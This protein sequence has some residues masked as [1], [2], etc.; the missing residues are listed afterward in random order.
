MS[1]TRTRKKFATDSSVSLSQRSQ[2]SSLHS[3]LAMARQK[4]GTLVTAAPISAFPIMIWASSMDFR[5][6]MVKLIHRTR[7]GFSCSAV[8]GE[9]PEGF[10]ISG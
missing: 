5:L 2:N 10:G 3:A 8:S 6:G 9:I 4:V 1:R 7:F